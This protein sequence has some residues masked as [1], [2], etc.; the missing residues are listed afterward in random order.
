MEPVTISLA[1]IVTDADAPEAQIKAAAEDIRWRRDLLDGLEDYNEDEEL[2]DDA[3]EF[4]DNL[5]R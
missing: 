4:L 1:D 5:Y 3:L 2:S